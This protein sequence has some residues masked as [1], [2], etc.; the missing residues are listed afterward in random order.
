MRTAA[1]DLKATCD[2]RVPQGPQPSDNRPNLQFNDFRKAVTQALDLASCRFK[3]GQQPAGRGSNQRST[4]CFITHE[5]HALTSQQWRTSIYWGFRRTVV[6]IA[7]VLWANPMSQTLFVSINCL[8]T[9]L[10]TSFVTH[11]M[12]TSGRHVNQLSKINNTI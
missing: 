11:Q 6:S 12:K 4:L 5:V 3:I 1:L 10:S 2:S 7:E 9:D 8:F